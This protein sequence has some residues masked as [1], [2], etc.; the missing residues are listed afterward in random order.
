MY[1]DGVICLN[2]IQTQD[3]QATEGRKKQDPV[4]LPIVLLFSQNL[5]ETASSSKGNTL[6]LCQNQSFFN[7][8]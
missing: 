2:T 3:Y 1:S 6:F 4:L 8:V 5:I 7:I